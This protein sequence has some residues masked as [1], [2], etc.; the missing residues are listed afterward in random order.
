LLL[1][2][3]PVSHSK[4]WI[5]YIVQNI[6]W[7]QQSKAFLN[8]GVFVFVFSFKDQKAFPASTTSGFVAFSFKL[9]RDLRLEKGSILM[10]ELRYKINRCS[11]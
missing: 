2:V 10:S 8:L 4:L 7:L 1:V 3:S 11:W 5:S 9:S 6:Q